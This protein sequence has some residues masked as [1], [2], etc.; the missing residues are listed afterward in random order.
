MNI[1]T[2]RRIIWQIF[3]I[4]IYMQIYEK[5]TRSSNLLETHKSYLYA[6]FSSNFYSEHCCV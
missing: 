3:D 6:I 2:E 5:V 1:M 4:G